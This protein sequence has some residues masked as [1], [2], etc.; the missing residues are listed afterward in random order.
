[1]SNLSNVILLM[2]FLNYGAVMVSSQRAKR[3][4]SRNETK[5]MNLQGGG[6]ITIN[7]FVNCLPDDERPG[8]KGLNNAEKNFL[9]DEPECPLTSYEFHQPRQTTDYIR[10]KTPVPDMYTGT[11]C[12]WISTGAD[13]MMQGT[14]VSY[15]TAKQFN[16]LILFGY[17]KNG[18]AKLDVFI[19]DEG[20]FTDLPL[21]KE[22]QIH[23]C[24]AFNVIGGYVKIFIDG[25][26]DKTIARF[27]KKVVI[28][29]GGVL[30]IGQEQDGLASGFMQDQ[31]YKGQISNF[32]MW[33]RELETR[34]IRVMADEG[35]EC[36]RDYFA[37]LT[38]D[39]VTLAGGVSAKVMKKCPATK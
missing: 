2:L 17:K 5:T 30:I 15:A 22:R 10:V 26:L 25:S 12:A 23:F 19:N 34:E 1:M 27:Q 21:T 14:L 37:A 28:E 32:M 16:S 9:L 33:D 4:P 38:P 3:R 31:S 36:P 35:C 24:A 39:S 13:G 20:Y 18:T 6:T 11:V 7:N 8:S 29:G